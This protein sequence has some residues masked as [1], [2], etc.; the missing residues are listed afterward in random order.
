EILES[1]IPMYVFQIPKDDHDKLEDR[2]SL[3]IQG[4]LTDAKISK[5]ILGRDKTYRAFFAGVQWNKGPEFNLIRNL[6]LKYPK[7]L[8]FYPFICEWE[9]EVYPGRSDLGKGD[10]ILT[11]GEERYL[12]V[13]AKILSKSSGRTQRNKR[14]K[15]KY[16][17]FHL[18]VTFLTNT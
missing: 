15:A 6:V 4:Y 5:D 16:T 3:V 11:D 7:E 2:L 10:I 8:F 1:G 18:E 13:E 14:R 17:F 9:G 12:I